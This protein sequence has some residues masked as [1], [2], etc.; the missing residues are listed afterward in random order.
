M[1]VKSKQDLDPLLVDL[2][3]PILKKFIEAFSQGG[4]GVLRYQVHLC[5][6]DVDGLRE[7]FLEE[8]HSSRYSIHPG[9]TKMYCDLREVYWGNAMKKDIAGFVA[10]C[11]NCQQVKVEHR[12]PKGLLQDI[13]ITIGS[14][15]RCTWILLCVFLVPEG[16]MIQLFQLTK[17][18]RGVFKACNGVKC[19]G[20]VI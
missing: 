6:P 4:D 11:P 3:E 15:K 8:A 16:N 19:K 9:C 7:I 14:G 17:D 5:V 12:R 20:M 18:Q 1:D 2:K 13:A 10:K